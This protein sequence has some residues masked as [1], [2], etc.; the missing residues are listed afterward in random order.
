MDYN[1][2]TPSCL[3]IEK[4]MDL[5]SLQPPQL[6]YLIQHSSDKGL[7]DNAWSIF[8]PFAEITDLRYF[9]KFGKT[10][11]IK[12]ECQIAILAHP[13]ADKNDFK[14][15]ADE[16]GKTNAISDEA[17][18]RFNDRA[19]S[20]ELKYFFEYGKTYSIRF[21]AHST[22]LNQ[23]DVSKDDLMYLAEY[24]ITDEIKFQAWDRYKNLADTDELRYFSTCVVPEKI[25]CEAQSLFLSC[26]ALEYDELIY[27]V[28]Q[29]KESE[30]RLGAWVQLGARTRFEDSVYFAKFAKEDTISNSCWESVD[31]KLNEVQLREFVQFG[32]TDKIAN[33]AWNRIKQNCKYADL[34]NAVKYG[35]TELIVNEAW[36]L[37]KSIAT[38]ADLSFLAQYA[39]NDEIALEA[40]NELNPIATLE[41]RTCIAKYGKT[42][43]IRLEA[44]EEVKHGLSPE[45]L[46]QIEKFSTVGSMKIEAKRLKESSFYT[47]INAQKEKIEF[48]WMTDVNL[49]LKSLK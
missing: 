40:W 1:H 23:P 3:Q 2:T 22:L 13:D 24:G 15:L 43:K 33:A 16:F 20:A 47:H 35:K 9:A 10:D 17:W 28:K 41:I 26:L 34:S 31:G 19:T 45:D 46:A 30:V 27:L 5:N 25:T 12:K 7:A 6:K 11:K 42:D 37:I 49:A 8:Q 38:E 44:W 14:Y 48:V 21:S 32:R 36:I 39:T 29:A 4:T 18:S